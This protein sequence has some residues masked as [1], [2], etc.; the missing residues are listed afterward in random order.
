MTTE[1]KTRIGK[2]MG[3]ERTWG[4]RPITLQDY[5]F[6]APTMSWPVHHS[7]MI[8]PTES[9][10]LAELD[11]F[12]DAM[13]S[14]RGEI[15]KIEN[16]EWDLKDNPLK[17]APHPEC[18]ICATEWNHCYTREEAAFPLPYIAERGKFW[19]SVA[20]VSNAYG[21]KNIKVKFDK[22]SHNSCDKAPHWE[23]SPT[24]SRRVWF[25]CQNHRRK[26]DQGGV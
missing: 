13:I 21:D 24:E 14:I 10:S 19:P 3:R 6:H 4:G 17:N 8:E 26:Q 20:R 22:L 12:C 1:K 11:R 23:G 7:L 15:T 25:T 5:G 16:G 2:Y 9:E 18:Q